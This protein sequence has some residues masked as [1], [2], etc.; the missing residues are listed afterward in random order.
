MTYYGGTTTNALV[1]Y[2]GNGNVMALVDASNGNVCARYEYGP[3]AEPIRVSGPMAKLNP[4]R[5]ST[6]YTDNEFGFL[7][8]GYR[9]FNPN[10]GRWLSRDPM[11]EQSSAT[12]Y[13]CCAN[14][15]ANRVDFFGLYDDCCCDTRKVKRGE[16]ILTLRYLRAKSYWE[17]Q[18][19]PHKEEDTDQYS[20]WE[21]NSKIL[22]FIT[23]APHCWTCN[24]ERRWS[25]RVAFNRDHWVVVCISH[26]MWGLP[27]EIMFDY[28]ADR[29]EAESPDR[30][31]RVRYPQPSEVYSSSRYSDCSQPE[32]PA[33]N[34]LWLDVVPLPSKQLK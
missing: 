28:W 15:P 1:A 17:S 31:F 5:F 24:L 20:C 30:W 21:L 4:I 12:L 27:K 32:K 18:G 8:Y 25:D 3:F 29:P 34:Y 23:P 9:Y 2:D 6:K 16:L 26:P 7:Y 13:G 11:E 33:E 22:S 10:T 14:D 19:V